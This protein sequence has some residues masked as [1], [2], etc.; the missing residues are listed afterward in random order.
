MSQADF[1]EAAEK[2]KSM[3]VD[4]VGRRRRHREQI[5]A[6]KAR[7]AAAAAAKYLRD[8]DPAMLLRSALFHSDKQIAAIAAD[9]RAIGAR[10]EGAFGPPAEGDLLMAGW[11]PDR[12]DDPPTLRDILYAVSYLGRRLGALI[13]AAAPDPAASPSADFIFLRVRLDATDPAAEA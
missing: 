9:L 10:L 13:P 2:I 12:P 3:A 4:F 6:R 5:E 1:A 7:D 8:T 11:L